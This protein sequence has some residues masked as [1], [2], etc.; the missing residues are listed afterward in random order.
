MVFRIIQKAETDSP[1]YINIETGTQAFKKK[2]W[3]LEALEAAACSFHSPPSS[4]P[5]REFYESF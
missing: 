3:F 2:K 1:T 5:F 4:V